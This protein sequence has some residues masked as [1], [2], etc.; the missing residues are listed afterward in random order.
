MLSI[1]GDTGKS[2]KY[3]GMRIADWGIIILRVL[4]MEDKTKFL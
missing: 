1:E 4:E 3:C 2:I